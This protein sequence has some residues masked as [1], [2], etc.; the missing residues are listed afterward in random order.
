M[1]KIK[2]TNEWDASLSAFSKMG[3]KYVNGWYSVTITPK[4]DITPLTPLLVQAE[5][6]FFNK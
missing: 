6:E 5:T 1:A 3:V 4:D 2:Q